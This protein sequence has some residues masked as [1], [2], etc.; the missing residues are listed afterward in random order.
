M[1]NASIAFFPSANVDGRLF[2]GGMDY[3]RRLC[4]WEPFTAIVGNP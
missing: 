3:D 4:L 1:I 2:S